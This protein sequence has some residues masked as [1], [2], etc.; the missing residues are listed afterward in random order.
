ME[1]VSCVAAKSRSHP[2]VTRAF[3]SAAAL[4][5][6]VRR[7]TWSVESPGRARKRL[8]ARATRV[9]VFPVPAEASTARSRPNSLAA[10][11]RFSFTAYAYAFPGRWS[12]TGRSAGS[13]AIR[14]ASA[15]GPISEPS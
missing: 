8:V 7:R 15:P 5:V 12:A 11:S 14:A 10:F 1:S 4:S 13:R 2:S 9:D 6:N 3:I